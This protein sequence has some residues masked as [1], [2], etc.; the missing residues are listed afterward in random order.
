[1]SQRFRTIT[2]WRMAMRQAELTASAI[3]IGRA[4]LAKWQD[5]VD[6]MP[7]SLA[8]RKANQSRIDSQRKRLDEAERDMMKL[9]ERAFELAEGLDLTS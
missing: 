6:A 3:E 7:Q 8:L 9:W 5:R 4:Q 2:N 1:M